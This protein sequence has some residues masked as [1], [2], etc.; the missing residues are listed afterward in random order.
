MKYEIDTLFT[1]DA[2]PVSI[3]AEGNQIIFI[4]DSKRALK[5]LLDL[6]FKDNIEVILKY[7]KNTRRERDRKRGY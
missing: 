7:E 1:K 2:Y 3:V 4:S 5:L 6:N